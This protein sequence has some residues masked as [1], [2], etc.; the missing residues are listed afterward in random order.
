MRETGS[1]LDNDG[2]IENPLPGD[3]GYTLMVG[4]YGFR[5]KGQPT[6]VFQLYA[7][8]KLYSVYDVAQTW[9][10]LKADKLYKLELNEFDRHDIDQVDQLMSSLSSEFK[11]LLSTESSE[12]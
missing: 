12:N 2:Q 6:T 8:N 11:E 10:K 4:L 1:T 7:K 3:Y 5:L 9:A